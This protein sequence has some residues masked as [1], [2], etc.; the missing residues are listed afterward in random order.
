MEAATLLFK[1]V[2]AMNTSLLCAWVNPWNHFVVHFVSKASAAKGSRGRPTEAA[3]LT[4][5]GNLMEQC[6]YARAFPYHTFGTAMEPVEV[7]AEDHE[8]ARPR[9]HQLVQCNPKC[10]QP[11]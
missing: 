4:P 9:G 6:A 1:G 8:A 3:G 10:E 11:E 7:V 2:Y 5:H